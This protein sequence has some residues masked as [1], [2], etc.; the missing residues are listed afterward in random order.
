MP[1]ITILVS[2]FQL[3]QCGLDRRLL[4]GRNL[5]AIIL[6]EVLGGEDHGVCLIHLVHF[7][8][9]PSCRFRHSAPAS[10]FMR[11]ISSLL[12]PDPSLDA[13]GLFLARCSLILGTDVQDTVGIDIECNLNLRNTGEPERYLQG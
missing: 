1:A 3:L 7:L 12:K 11:S 4:V 2:I 5:V 8:A 9:F 6:Q 10:A 13:D